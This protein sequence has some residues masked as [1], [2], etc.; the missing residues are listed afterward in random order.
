MALVAL[1]VKLSSLGPVLFRQQRPGRA[2][3]EFSVLKFRTMVH[4]TGTSAGPVLTRSGD[5]RITTVGR[6]LR[7]WKLDELPQLVNVLRGEMSFVG[8]RPQP[9]KLWRDPMLQQEMEI[10][11]SVRPG[12]TS[13]A[14]LRFRNEEE[15]LAG[16]APHEIE[17]RYLQ[18]VMPA[19][20]KLDIEYLQRATF[21]SDLQLLFNTVWRIVLPRAP[22]EDS[23]DGLLLEGRERREAAE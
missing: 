12:I 22:H 11:L 15:L 21:A 18:A 16:L 13:Q 5:E 19:K 7:K 9:V 4:S 2:W 6:F 17:E 20:L 14:T 1:A 8:P 23:I 3:R 10:V